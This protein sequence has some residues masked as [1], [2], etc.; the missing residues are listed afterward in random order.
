MIFFQKYKKR[1]KQNGSFRSEFSI[2][3][4]Y[5][6]I[7]QQGGNVYPSAHFFWKK[8]PQILAAMLYYKVAGESCPAGIPMAG[9]L[10]HALAAGCKRDKRS[11]FNYEIT[12]RITVKTQGN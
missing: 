6:V 9:R 11:I 2:R 1:Q 4:L 12:G 3:A 10:K 8:L 7:G 5:F